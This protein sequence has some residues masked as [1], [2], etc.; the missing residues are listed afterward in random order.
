M[1]SPLVIVGAGGFGRETADAVMA[2]NDDGPTWQLLGFAD[3][4]PALRGK[5]VAGVEVLGPID[6]VLQTFP[7]VMMIVAT[8]RPDNYFS[9]SRLVRRLNLPRQRF[10]SLVHP[11]ASVARRATVGAG[12]VLLAGVVVTAEATIGDH[13][14]VMPATVITHDDRIGD[15][16]TLAS[17]VRLGGSVSVGTGAYVGA[18]ALVR[19]ELEIGSW[20]LIGMG[21]VVTESVPPAQRWFGIPA[22][23][24]SDVD[25]PP[26]LV[27]PPA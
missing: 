11:A 18:G 13:V 4:D 27:S 6:Q 3:D 14:A 9:R 24:R 8:G 17:G 7:D 12:T 19:E 23:F 20:S 22:R 26:D 15:Y 16:A 21:S 5:S 25:V 1:T 10:A 2:V